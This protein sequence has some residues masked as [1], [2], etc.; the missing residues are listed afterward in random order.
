MFLYETYK[1]TE[2]AEDAINDMLAEGELFR[3]EIA[4][5]RRLPGRRRIGLFLKEIGEE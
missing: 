1:S 5:V 4:D 2:A 3:C